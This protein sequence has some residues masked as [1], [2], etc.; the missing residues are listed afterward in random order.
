MLENCQKDIITPEFPSHK[1]IHQ[2]N[3]II[4]EEKIIESEKSI[5]IFYLLHSNIKRVLDD[6]LLYNCK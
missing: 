3:Q 2:K 5:E 6:S 1:I 4:N